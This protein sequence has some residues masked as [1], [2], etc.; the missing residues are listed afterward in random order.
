VANEAEWR[1]AE[2]EAA[3]A[4]EERQAKEDA[5]LK[6]E[7]EAARKRAKEE[8]QE[9]EAALKR[10]GWLPFDGL[11]K[12]V[13]ARVRISVG[14][15]EGTVR[16]ALAS[17][18]VRPHRAAGPVL[19]TYDDGLLDMNLRPGATNKGGV[20]PDGKLLVQPPVER[21][22]YSVDDFLYWLRL[23]PPQAEPATK[24]TK[25]VAKPKKQGKGE[26]AKQAIKA[27][28][29]DGIP[30]AT[31][32]PNKFFCPEVRKWLRADCKRL[33]IPFSDM[34]NKTILRAARVLGRK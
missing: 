28:W 3:R 24:Q 31:R 23:N 27:R 1:N 9:R 4:E 17:G 6:A 20:S 33:G 12:I 19:L 16:K 11:V 2:R 10:A 5:R 15:A 29:P 26:R 7:Y 8:W 32:L 34:D 13:L 18:D 21:R 25:S 14:A 30:D 22:H